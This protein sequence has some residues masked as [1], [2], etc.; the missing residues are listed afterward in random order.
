[1]LL[2]VCYLSSNSA[3]SQKTGDSQTALVW[4]NYSFGSFHESV[5]PEDTL[6]N[7]NSQGVAD[8]SGWTPEEWLVNLDLIN[9]CQTERGNSWC[10]GLV[11]PLGF[12]NHPKHNRFVLI[13]HQ[14][15]IFSECGF[16]QSQWKKTS[17][18][19]VSIFFTFPIGFVLLEWLWPNNKIMNRMLICSHRGTKHHTARTNLTG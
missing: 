6:I 9:D 4:A 11:E 14:W 15:R 1:M 12:S 18:Y 5:V 3:M 2:L 7:R 16:Y 19:Y 17:H 13:S 8:A 10:S